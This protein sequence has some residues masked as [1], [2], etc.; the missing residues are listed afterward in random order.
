MKLFQGK[1]NNS[2]RTAGLTGL[3]TSASMTG[4]LKTSHLTNMASDL[5]NPSNAS[6]WTDTGDLPH[7]SFRG[8]PKIGKGIDTIFR[9]P[10]ACHLPDHKKGSRV[11]IHLSKTRQTSFDP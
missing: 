2:A 6:R 10:F 8:I 7:M 11:W 1:L 5:T 3:S 9:P 4:G